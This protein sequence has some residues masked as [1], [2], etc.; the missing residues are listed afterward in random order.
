MK[1]Q[2]PP[3]K[4]EKRPEPPDAQREPPTPAQVAALGPKAAADDD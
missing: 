2:T 3:L 1:E 4:A